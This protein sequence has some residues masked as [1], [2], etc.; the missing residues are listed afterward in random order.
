MINNFLI[1]L[2]F[3]PCCS[4]VDI[5]FLSESFA[6]CLCTPNKVNNIKMISTARKWF[7]EEFLSCF[8][9]GLQVQQPEKKPKDDS[10]SDIDLFCSDSEVHNF[11]MNVFLNHFT[12]FTGHNLLLT[13]SSSSSNFD[14]GL[15]PLMGVARY[16]PL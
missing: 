16:T 5:N 11:I 6:V 13:S 3:L 2:L 7:F 8:S 14:P 10:D 4:S 12:P 15:S 9:I 1:S